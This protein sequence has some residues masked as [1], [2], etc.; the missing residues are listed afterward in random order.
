[1]PFTVHV[2]SPVLE[3]TACAGREFVLNIIT[4]DMLVP[5]AQARSH[6]LGALQCNT[7]RMI[8]QASSIDWSALSLYS[9]LGSAASVVTR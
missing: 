5:V 1:M 7:L 9:T 3:G 4:L 6:C 2:I 8:S